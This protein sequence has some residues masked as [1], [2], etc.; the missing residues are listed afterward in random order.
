MRFANHFPIPTAGLLIAG[1]MTLGFGGSVF[2]QAAPQEFTYKLML[3]T[4]K[5]MGTQSV[6]VAPLE[7]EPLSFQVDTRMK[8]DFNVFLKHVE[9]QQVT[10]EIWR[11]ARI[12]GFESKTVDRG[13]KYSVVVTPDGEGLQIKTDSNTAQA[14]I[15]AV[16]SSWWY[17]PL[18]K[19]TTEMFDTKTGEVTQVILR[20]VD[21]GEATYRGETYPVA[22]YQ[23]V[24]GGKTREIWYFETGIMYKIQWPEKL[25]NKVSYT[26]Q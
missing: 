26:L 20:F 13:D 7:G 17:Q 24:G 4:D 18:F 8:I 22:R 9:V 2:A 3:N 12:A 21:N 5:E 23:T 11:N 14:A 10:R 1:A 19:D 6:T 15:T 16:P 25:G